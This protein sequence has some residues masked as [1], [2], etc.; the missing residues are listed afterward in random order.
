[1]EVYS[2]H[3]IAKA[4]AE[5]PRITFKSKILKLFRVKV[6]GFNRW[7]RSIAVSPGYVRDSGKTFD[8][9]VISNLLN[10]V[11]QLFSIDSEVRVP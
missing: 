1:V 9:Q 8:N 2:E 5:L 11:K 4:I 6:R 10:Q 3:P 7:K